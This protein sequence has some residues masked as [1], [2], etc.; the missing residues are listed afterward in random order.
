MTHAQFLKLAADYKL[1]H[2]AQELLSTSV[3]GVR[4]LKQAMREASPDARTFIGGS[5]VPIPSRWPSYKETPLTFI[6]QVDTES[7]PDVCPTRLPL[8]ILQFFVPST[9][10]AN[11][12]EPSIESGRVLFVPTGGSRS[13]EDVELH[14]VDSSTAPGER[15]VRGASL[16]ARVARLFGVGACHDS[17]KRHAMTFPKRSF[18]WEVF[19]TLYG[20]APDAESMWLPETAQEFEFDHEADWDNYFEFRRAVMACSQWDWRV[21][22]FGFANEQQDDMQ[23]LVD[24]ASGRR[25]LNEFREW[26]LLFALNSACGGLAPEAVCYYFWIHRDDLAEANFEEVWLCVQQD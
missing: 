25:S 20:S 24:V 2:I 5:P 6:S 3:P 23:P 9:S 8:G 14:T 12:S 7:L 26:I 13:T 10:E 21:Q 15:S 1:T 18:Q 17:E 4:A 11:D 22:M 19:P 16:T